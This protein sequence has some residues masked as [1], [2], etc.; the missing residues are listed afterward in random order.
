MTDTALVIMARYP[1]A[2][3]TKTRL[4]RTIGDAAT[5]HLYRAFLTD[6]VIKFAGTEWD[7]YMTYTPAGIDYNA[8]LESLVPTHARRVGVF[9]QQGAG[10]GE[11]LLS[12]FRWT[13]KRGYR[14]TIVIGS[15][16]PHISADAVARARAALDDA[17]VALG[18]AEDG[19][20]YL[21]AMRQPHDVFRDI[22]MSTDKVLQMTIDLAERQGLR[23]RTLETMF[24]VDEFSDLLRLSHALRAD[25]SL[26]PAT[27]SHLST[28][29]ELV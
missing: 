10:L 4:A 23:V 1:Q 2:G 17:D 21:I 16:S 14:R 3:T 22:P 25:S 6:L 19:G 5:L 26:A 28:I 29:K 15:D 12:A 11:R 24:D 18:P 8:F 20:Y 13:H 7:P 27:A 9:P